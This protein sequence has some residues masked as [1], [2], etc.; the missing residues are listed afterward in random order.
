M[1]LFSHYFKQ[2]RGAILVFLCFC[3]IFAAA[4]WLYHIPIQAV[5]YP[6]MLC[7]LLGASVIAADIIHVRR[8]HAQLVKMQALNAAMIHSFPECSSIEEADY[9]QIIRVLKE[10][11]AQLEAT[12]TG[13]YADMIDY[14]TVWAHQIKTPI[15][16][17]RLTLQN[18][19]SSLSRKLSGELFRIEQYVTMALA[20]LRLDSSSTD[21]LF[22]E[23]DLDAIIRQ[24][25]KKFANEFICKKIHLDYQP[26]NKTVITDEKW[27]AFALEQI[28]SNALKYTREG[29]VKIYMNEQQTLCVQDTGIGIAPSD[30]PRIFEKGYTGYNGR[31]DKKASGLGLY[32]CK[33]ILNNLGHSASAVSSLGHGTTI[34][35]NLEQY[36][37]EKE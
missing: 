20:F 15:A 33:R 34:C 11:Q 4:F 35:V 13:R 7:C 36:P 30:L 27:F 23:Y 16:S 14:Y 10:E 8:K 32:L 1:K 2:R 12:M 17:M 6:A 3:A 28:L 26:V 24:S 18:E 22:K 9:Q 31:Q 25:V 21:Y 29:S 5:A 19:D 37:W